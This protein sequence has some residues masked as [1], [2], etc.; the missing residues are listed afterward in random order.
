MKFVKENEN[1]DRYVDTV[2]SVV[3]AAKADPEGINAT[4]GCLYNEEGKLFTYRSVYEQEKKIT[5]IQ[6]ASYAASPAGNAGYVEA[7][8]RFVLEDKVNNHH[9]AM[10]TPG[11]TG[12]IFAA[13]RMC[14][15]EGDEILYPAISW[16]NYKVMASEMNLK[17][18]TYDIYDLDDLFRKLDAIPSKVFLIVNSPCENPLGHSYSLE[19]WRRIKEKLVSLNREV[20]LLCDIAY[21]DYAGNDPKAFLELFNDIPDDL[22]VLIAASASKAFSYYGQRIGALIAIHN[23]PA[24]LDHFL[25]LSSRLARATWSNLSNAAMLN[26]T[27][28]LEHHNE[29]YREE[30]M[31]AKEMLKKR[32][33]LFIRQAEE[34]GL[35]LYR[36][37]DGFFVTIEMEDNET[38]DIFHQ[39]LIEHHI[40]TIKV[41][42]GIRVALC[43]LS[44][45]TVDGLAGKIKELM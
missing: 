13:M 39:K 3:R 26:I 6:R 12:A 11:G 4:A 42:R 33:D 37:S 44:L 15:D 43:S 45:E 18:S 8:S 32:T 41:N 27:E 23:D 40:Y 5:P 19:E 22:L 2:F 7:I 28:V 25:N 38:R 30:L 1:T 20:V 36:F 10:A 9:V 17:V 35:K 14:L 31:Q 29:E 21:I 24:F 34:C 16:G